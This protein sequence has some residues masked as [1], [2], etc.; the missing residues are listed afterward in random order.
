MWSKHWSI[1][2]DHMKY[3][4]NKIVKP[5]RVEIIQYADSFCD[6]YKLYKY[7]PPPSKKGDDYDKVDWTVR[8]K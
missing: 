5:F 3:I 8:D 2:Q 7:Q 6:M 1:F 4:H